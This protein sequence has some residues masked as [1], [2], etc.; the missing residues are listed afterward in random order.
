MNTPTNY[1]ENRQNNKILEYVDRIKNGE[2]KKSIF[3]GL[4][5]SWINQIEEKL[6]SKDKKEIS[7]N[8]IPPQHRNLDSESL[9]FIWGDIAV[10]KQ[11]IH[12]RDGK[13]FK[14]E[15]E[16]RKAICDLL[17][18]KENKFNVS[19]TQTTEQNSL[20]QFKSQ[21]NKLD[22]EKIKQEIENNLKIQ[23]MSIQENWKDIKNILYKTQTIHNNNFIFTKING[24]F[25]LSL[26]QDKNNPKKWKSRIFRF[27]GSD[28]Q[29][30]FL[31][32]YR[33]DGHHFMK[34]DESNPNHHY[35]QSAKLDSELILAIQSLESDTKENFLENNLPVK[36]GKYNEE[37]KEF[38]EE[39]VEFKNESWKYNQDINKF[40]FNF[41]NKANNEK[42]KIN[43]IKNVIELFIK[44]PKEK[45][46]WLN[47]SQIENIKSESQ[48]LL[49]IFS[50]LE[51]ENK[52]MS[53][54][55]LKK[56]KSKNDIT[57][58]Y[59]KSVGTIIKI[60]F[61][62][63]LPIDM[64]PKFNKSEIIK[65]Y[66]KKCYGEKIKIEEYKVKNK[67]GDELIFA[68]AKDFKNRV[69]IDNIYDPNVGMNDYGI[70][71]K[72]AN[73]G[74]LVYKPEDY[75][76][77]CASILPEYKEKADYPYIDISKLWMENVPVIKDYIE[78]LKKRGEL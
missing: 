23:P 45:F 38:K 4:P 43:S 3:E 47:T 5:P 37:L 76:F 7:L 50:E 14:A 44:T 15:I 60:L 8:D 31:P 21:E 72:I 11:F 77:Q 28:N 67:N 19:K 24:E 41:Y 75:E 25:V 54:E 1:Y 42:L 35:V 6:N 62:K 52:N 61:Q 69:Y 36:N 33:E 27:S 65:K 57:K 74:Y 26:V 34:G 51:K 17:E 78:E 2:D 58:K 55:D 63:P 49:N 12:D 48:N 32:G 18:E 59:N 64:T 56:D 40:I 13:I 71:S 20:N 73:M 53:F 9:R 16:R 29:W 30:K 70:Q 22:L 66:E 10:I 39:Y 68:M 46:P